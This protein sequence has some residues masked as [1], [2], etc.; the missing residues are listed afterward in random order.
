[1]SARIAIAAA[2]LAA[3]WA[4]AAPAPAAAQSGS[5]SAPP[6]APL[7]ERIL[8]DSAQDSVAITA[9]FSGSDLFVYGAI[10]RNRFLRPGEAA[11]DV[12]IVIEGPSAPLMVRRKERVAGIW[13][14]GRGVRIAAAPSFYAVSSTRP[15]TEILRPDED[16]VHGVSLDR[17]V[18]IF[19]IPNSAEDPEQFRQALIRLRRERDLYQER[20]EGVSLK[21]GTLYQTQVRLPANIVEGLYKIR[22]YLIR[23]GIVRDEAALEIPVQKEGI[24][25]LIFNAAQQT[26]FM[27]GALTLLTALLA[28]FGASELFRRLRR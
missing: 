4:A 14:N 5:P 22:V 6:R 19:G 18:L 1:M 27:Y 25:R 21:S 3:L 2:L 7:E 28:G 26:P 12:A 17:A 11:P 24:E 16:R 15:L 8:F 9:T 23:G 20:G 10:G 13:V